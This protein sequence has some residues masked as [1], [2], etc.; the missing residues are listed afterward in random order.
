MISEVRPAGIKY[1]RGNPDFKNQIHEISLH[2]ATQQYQTS[3][4]RNLND[5]LISQ[6]AVPLNDILWP[7]KKITFNKFWCQLTVPSPRLC[8]IHGSSTIDPTC[9]VIF[10]KFDVLKD[11]S[12][13][14]SLIDWFW[15]VLLLLLLLLLVKLF[16]FNPSLKLLPLI[17]CLTF[18]IKF[19]FL[20]E[21]LMEFGTEKFPLDD[22]DVNLSL[23]NMRV[24]FCS[25]LFG[26]IRK[27]SETKL[28]FFCGDKHNGWF[29]NVKMTQQ[30][31]E[32][33]WLI[34]H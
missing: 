3:F 14:V 10:V 22:V 21:S 23:S 29:N 33:R 28:V 5:K 9:A 34:R 30:R 1:L 4:D 20:L 25:T 15:L 7:Q 32:K 19:K 2:L 6:Q 13:L 11:V 17:V 8:T 18:F 31:E 27:P 12:I 24:W 26:I 16:D